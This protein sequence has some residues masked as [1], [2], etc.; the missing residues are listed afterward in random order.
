[1]KKVII[2]AGDPAGI[3]PFIT[4]QAIREIDRNIKITL[5][6][7]KNVL[8]GIPGFSDIISRIDLIDLNN[9]DNVRAGVPSGHSGRAA[10]E[11]LQKAVEILRRKKSSFL[12]TA[13]LS[14]EFVKENKKGF[15]GHTEFLAR[16]FSVD[17][18]AMMMAGKKYRI[19]FFTRHINIRD[20]LS[21]LFPLEIDNTLRL[22]IN[23]LKRLFNI[24]SPKI[25][26]CGCNP[27][28]GVDTYLEKEEEII[29]SAVKK[30]QKE[31]DK[32]DII[33]P[34]PADT[35]FREY[36][37]EE[38]DL[39][40]ACYHDQGMIPFRL[41]DFTGGVNITL[42]LPFIRTSPAHGPAFDLMLSKSKIDH[43]PMKKAITLASE[44]NL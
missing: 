40:I 18:F 22:S 25:A 19:V 16:Q 44:L 6:G 43:R 34:Y 36:E 15:T 4:V 3:S 37:R 13:P 41:L 39:V 14:K 24:E 23:S 42:G 7:D 38:F 27:H 33:G 29:H 28:A 12:V 17:K 21:N 20:I 10:M 11:Y 9:A 32:L 2:T 30:I 31:Y 26:V 35:L 8:K 1:M 5:I